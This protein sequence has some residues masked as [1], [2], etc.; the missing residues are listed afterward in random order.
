[1]M[2]TFVSQCQKKA[3]NR[4][5]RVLDAFA[6]RIGDNT[7]Q[8]VITEDGLTAVKKLLR[9]TATKNTAVSQLLDRGERIQAAIADLKINDDSWHRVKVEVRWMI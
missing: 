3:L 7:W 8:T 5:R 6:N 4:T 1:M 9:K 2:V